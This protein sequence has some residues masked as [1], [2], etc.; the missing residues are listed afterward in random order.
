M[1]LT[2]TTNYATKNAQRECY[3]RAFDTIKQ[4]ISLMRS[5]KA[6]LVLID[7]Q[8]AG[9]RSI[10]DGRPFTGVAIIFERATL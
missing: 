8:S 7:Q 5:I 2:Y 3:L 1:S 4:C 6:Y 9:K 10:Q